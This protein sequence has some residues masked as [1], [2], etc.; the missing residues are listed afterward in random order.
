M[1]TDE[2]SPP[3]AAKRK[4]IA[5][6]WRGLP[7]WGRGLWILAAIGF[8]YYL[9]ELGNIPGTNL[10]LPFLSFFRTDVG[11]AGSDWSS[12]LFR[13]AVYVLIAIGLNVVV[14]LA[15]LLDLGYVGFFA[16]GAYSVGL[17]GSQQS[18][19]VKILRDK[20]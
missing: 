11:V 17:F 10:E 14:G 1:S 8:L 18:P 3:K 7:K 9:P 20:F 16:L 15:G 2:L 19:V 12:I 13:C 4:S 6:R 5:D